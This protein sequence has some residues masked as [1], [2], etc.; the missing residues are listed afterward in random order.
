MPLF[1]RWRWLAGRSYRDDEDS[2]STGIMPRR[3]SVAS[4]DQSVSHVA[5]ANDPGLRERVPRY[6][7]QSTVD[8]PADYGRNDADFHD[9][10]IALWMVAS[11]PFG[12]L[13][14]R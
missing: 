12:R 3:F 8:F 6:C 1:D 11:P 5:A 10:D 2:Q 9:G 14:F 4:I 7:R 13:L